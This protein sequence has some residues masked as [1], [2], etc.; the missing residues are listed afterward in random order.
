MRRLVVAPDARGKLGIDRP[1]RHGHQ[2]EALGAASGFVEVPPRPARA[3]E[4]RPQVVAAVAFQHDAGD[5]QAVSVGERVVAI[6][7]SAP[8]PLPQAPMV[9]PEAGFGPNKISVFLGASVIGRGVARFLLFG[10]RIGEGK[11]PELSLAFAVDAGP[12]LLVLPPDRCLANPAPAPVEAVEAAAA[13]KRTTRIV[14][15]CR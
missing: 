10:P 15:G 7:V 11:A 5:R 4:R 9:R 13:T 2:S 8:R 1:Q 14:N 12:L 6:A 3:R